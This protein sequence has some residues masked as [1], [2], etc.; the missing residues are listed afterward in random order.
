M[1]LQTFTDEGW[2]EDVLQSDLPVVAM[3]EAPWDGGCKQFRPIFAEVAS[4]FEG[5]V[6]FGTLDMD[7]HAKVPTSLKVRTLPS[8]AFVK[9]GEL[10]IL[11]PG[12]KSTAELESL[13][14]T[15]LDREP[16]TPAVQVETEVADAAAGEDGQTREQAQAEEEQPGEAAGEEEAA[17]AAVTDETWEAQALGAEL[18]VVVDFWAA[19]CPPCKQFSPI[20]ERFAAEQAGR[21]RCLKLDT[22]ANPDVSSRYNVRNIPTILFLRSG[23]EVGRETGLRTIPQLEQLAERYFAPTDS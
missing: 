4:R 9:R 15:H 7:E 2:R 1:E 13:I 3:M 22:D 16:N 23:Q 17:M 21:I 8:L 5:V 19:W 11:V 10:V 14:L 6:R 18:P 20:F 12:V